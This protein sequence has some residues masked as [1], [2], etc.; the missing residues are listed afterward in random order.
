MRSLQGTNPE[1]ALANHGTW[2]GGSGA[3]WAA[4]ATH[5]FQSPHCTT[6]MKWLQPPVNCRP[7][8]TRLKWTAGS[9]LNLQPETAPGQ[10]EELKKRFFPCFRSGSTTRRPMRA[11]KSWSS[12]LSPGGVLPLVR[13]RLPPHRA[14][15]E[16]SRFASRPSGFDPSRKSCGAPRRGTRKRG[17]PA[18][19]AITAPFPGATIEP[20]SSLHSDPR[21]PLGRYAHALRVPFPVEAMRSWRTPGRACGPRHL[22]I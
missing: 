7:L 8:V 13:V 1:G 20:V 17:P 6:R 15:V 12:D 3:V 2:A 9:T 4:H 5:H 10:V 19:I 16:P 21:A 22:S 18:A 14:L 11:R